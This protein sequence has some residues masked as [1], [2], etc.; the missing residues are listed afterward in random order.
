MTVGVEQLSAPATA[1][2]NLPVQRT[3]FVGRDEQIAE[4][5]QLLRATRVLTLLGAGGCGK[6]RLALR[7]AADV[8]GGFPDG[9][10]FVDFAPL[11]DP[12]LVPQTVAQVLGVRETPGR[13]VMDTL[14]QHLRLRQILVILDNCEHVI[15]TSAQMADALLRTCPAVRILATSREP[16]RTP[17]ET[18]WRV[19][20]LSLPPPAGVGAST[21]LDLTA[22]ESVKLFVDRALAA[23]PS[24]RLTAA[25]SLAVQEICRAL[26]GIPLAIELAAARVRVLSVEQIAARLDDRFRLLTAGPRTA[27]P[28]QQTLQATVDWSYALLSEPEKTALRQLSVFAGGWTIEAAEILTLADGVRTQSAFDV[29]ASLV[30]KSLSIAELHRGAM[31]HRLLETIRQYAY[32][33]LEEAG[34]AELAR[35][36]HLSYFLRL[37]EEIEPKLQDRRARA[38]MDQLE[39]E[40]DNLR[41]A[42][43]WALQTRPDTAL[44]L[45]AALGWFWWGRDYHTEGRRWLKRSLAASTEPT[46]ARMKAL[47]VS[48]WIAHHQRDLAEARNLLNESLAIAHQCRDNRS[49]AW[50]LHCLG[51]VA[52]F[53]GDSGAARSMGEQSLAVAEQIGDPPLV[54]WAHHLL[55]LAAYIGA[56][57][58]RARLH[59]NRSLA[60]RHELGFEEGICIL[61]ILLGLVA[62]REGDLAEARV[63]CQEGLSILRGLLGP[64]GVAMPLAAL[65]HIAARLGAPVQAVRFGA[66]ATYLGESYQTPLIPLVE[67]LLADG[68]ELARQALGA[69]KYLYAWAAGQALS[70]QTATNEALALD[71]A[72]ELPE[73]IESAEKADRSGSRLTATEIQV[74]RLL[75]RGRTSKEIAAELVV[76][77]STVDRHLTHIYT[78]LGVRNRA[79][80]TAL[81]LNGGLIKITPT[82]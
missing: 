73:P 14:Q 55:G 58:A 31:R 66:A 79:E 18:T 22:F 20:A 17:G 40:I 65:S 56:D 1:L 27:M 38:A 37:A 34:D 48:G 52:Y 78:K 33:R 45:S 39:A 4:I 5:V 80:A 54:A 30:D 74:L 60:I 28:R 64:W 44:R 3:S 49:V 32:Q 2:N 70:L 36:R 46:P 6:T 25:T 26:D 63:L 51:R 43:E 12:T 62:V 7:V 29:L 69:E 50:V 9:V 47:Y 15:D 72:P 68:L 67:P 75:V 11:T 23:L 42:L 10:W 61:T 35:N 57:Y 76:A 71:F 19:P 82:G 41:T 8:S 13:S 24:F 21:L 16:L 53:E 59:Y 81:A 77:V